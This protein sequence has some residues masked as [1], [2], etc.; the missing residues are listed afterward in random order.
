M[1]ASDSAPQLPVLPATEPTTL[2][3]P[4]AI[5]A[6]RYDYSACQLDILFYLLSVLRREDAATWEYR[7]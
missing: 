3:Q 4:N 1:T 6:A 5:V 2:Q 7:L